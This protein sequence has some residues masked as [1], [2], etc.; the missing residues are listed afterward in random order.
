MQNANL[1]LSPDLV[2]S[3]PWDGLC[4]SREGVVGAERGT[5]H[6]FQGQSVWRGPEQHEEVQGAAAYPISNSYDSLG[7]PC[8]NCW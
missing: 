6:R 5:T 7:A 8:L 3:F 2:Q 4:N 1:I